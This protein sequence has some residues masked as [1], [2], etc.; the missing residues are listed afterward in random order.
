MARM[1]TCGFELQSTSAEFGVNSGVIVTGSP[2]ISTTVHRAGTASLRINPTAATSFVEHQLTSGVV[3]RTTHRL[4]LRVDTLPSTATN[5]YGIGQ[6]GYFP[7]LLRLQ[8]D[9]T[10][11]LRDGFTETTLTPSPSAAGTGSSWTTTTSP[12]PSRPV[13]PPSRVTSTV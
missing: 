3:M 7:A 4:Y 12:A 5:V 11:V 10:L 2:S 6:S 9:G 8:T 1:W 13:S